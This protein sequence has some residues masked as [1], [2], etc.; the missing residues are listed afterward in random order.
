MVPYTMKRLIIPIILIAILLLTT[1]NAQQEDFEAFGPVIIKTF[2]CTTHQ[3]PITIQNTGEIESTYYLEVDGTAADWVQFAPTSVVL[4]PGETRTIQSFLTAPCDSLGEYTLD[5]YI[6][7]SY[8]LEKAILQ[9]ITVE[10]PLNIDILANVFS[11]SIP[12]CQ[13]AKY[14]LTI[15]NPAAF[16]ETYSFS[17]NSFQNQAELS[18]KKLT[19]QA[20]TSKEVTIEIT[21]TNCEQIGNHNIIFS[22]EA[23]K[24]GT[25]AEIDLELEIKDTGIP[26]IAEG[27]NSIKTKLLEESAA[28]LTVLNQGEEIKTYSLEID[29]PAWVTTDIT[30]LEIEGKASEKFLLFIKPPQD[31]EK[32]EYPVKITVIDEDNAKYSK[33]ITI[34]LISSTFLGKLFTEYLWQTIVGIVVFILLVIGIYFAVNYF[35]SEESKIARAKRKREREKK[36]AELKKQKKMLETEKKKEKGRKEKELDKAREKAIQKYDQKIKSEYELVSKEDI[37]KGQKIPTRWVFNLALFFIILIIFA[38]A[39][40]FYNIVWSYKYY[41]LAGIA[42]LLVLLILKQ[43]TK[44]KT[45]IARWRG[46]VLANEAL[47]MNI[48][49]KKGLYELSFKLDSPAKKVKVIA[50]QG[51]TR[52]ARYVQPK[53]YVYRYFRIQSTIQDVDIKESRYRF[54]VDKKWLRNR[55]IKDTEVA[56]AVLKD[57][58][59]CKLKTVREGTDAKYVY[60][61]A[62]TESFG[63]F[64][65]VGKTSA[66]EKK[67]SYTWAIVALIILILIGGGMA[68]LLTTTDEPIQVKGI[69]PQIW[70]TG[71]QHTLDLNKY[72]QD[73]DGD[74]LEYVYT[75]TDNIEIWVQDSTA[76]FLPDLDWSGQETTVFTADDGKG[77][78]IKSNPVV[79][80]VKKPIFPAEYA[81]YLK[82]IL[83]G[84]IILIL[85]LAILILRKPVMNWLDE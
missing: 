50:K 85:I 37:V 75:E 80:V 59:Y 74:A 30:A 54:K 35:T 32:G 55:E 40:N 38:V 10:K 42:I 9:D 31:A 27:I 71:K 22:A 21:P 60:Y 79:L 73:P 14:E 83:T 70:E 33:E 43:L 45:S 51:R 19:L 48:N 24:T 1:A 53:E 58:K 26:L 29:G 56:L 23:E 7:T 66:K 4:K 52:H 34:K 65:I 78:I 63:Q 12:P 49:W 68:I 41:V 61:R 5:I 20:N 13:T 25:I 46:L 47:L 36:K 72:F 17:L 76:Y 3:F 64:A 81:G 44:L 11:Q 8:G 16:T 15:V 69:Q 28:E 77:G 6:V 18:T 39:V 67:K 2:Q 82:Y 84:I 57:G 62:V